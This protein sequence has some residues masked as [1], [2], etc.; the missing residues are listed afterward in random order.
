MRGYSVQAVLII[1]T[2][3]L[4]A[5]AGTAASMSEIAPVVGK[6]NI[7]RP[8]KVCSA[9]VLLSTTSTPLCT[10]RSDAHDFYAAQ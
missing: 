7:E 8:P 10:V 5:A 2:R 4:P 1:F 3:A 9:E 6:R